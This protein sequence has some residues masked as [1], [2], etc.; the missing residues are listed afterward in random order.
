MNIVIGSNGFLGSYISYKIRDCIKVISD[1]DKNLNYNELNYNKFI[2]LLI[3]NSYNNATIYICVDYKNITKIIDDLIKYENI[4]NTIILFSSAVIYDGINKNKYSETDNIDYNLNSDEY[5]NNV[6]NNE[7]LFQQL[8]GNKIIIRLGTLY[9]S[10][11]ILNASRGIHRM[12]YF[13]LINNYLE[14]YDIKIKKSLTSFDDLYNA[15]QIILNNSMSNFEIFNVSS[16]DTTIEELGIYISNKFKVPI[17]Y[18]KNNKKNYNFNLDVSKLKSLGWVPQSNLT[19][20]IETI[21]CNFNELKEIKYDNIIIYYTKKNCRVCNSNKLFK[22]LDLKNQ[23]PPNRLSDPFW[24]LLNF[25]LILNGCF[26]CYHL[27]LN[28]VLNPIIMYKNY[29]YLSGTSTTMK[30]YFE[31]FV[32]NIINKENKTILDIACNDCALLDCFKKYNF[33]TYGIDPAENIVSNITNH[34]IYCGFFNND[35][36]K[37]FNKKFDIITAFNVFAHVDN[38]YDFL[39]N[40]YNITDINSDIYIQTS[41]CNMIINNE[42]DTIYHEHL[43]FFNIN[44]IIMALNNSNLKLVNINIMDVHG[45][46]YLFHIKHNLNHTIDNSNYNIIERINFENENK[47]LINDTY[48]N[49]SQNIYKWKNKLINLLK[50]KTNLI[51][52]G[53]SAKGITILNFIKNDLITNNINILYIIDENTLKIDKNIDSVNIKIID[54][55]YIKTIDNNIIFILFAWNYKDELIKKIKSIRTYTDQFIN[56]FPLEIL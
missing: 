20:L 5:V 13:P 12:I 51:G 16:F 23:P 24:Q 10:S 47:L 32:K 35:S 53:A 4:N 27:Q 50:N 39:N 43:S 46:S 6:K 18:L 1:N 41:Q 19:N 44:S 17:K 3:Q 28:G 30:N 11:L 26:N 31:Y 37:Y 7:I 14:L 55:N 48:I 38:I 45:S 33:E 40:I 34:N 29:S 2:N 9:G 8:K 42:F 36:I 54:F 52:V 56:L 15:I 21:T 22:I 49:Y 25:P